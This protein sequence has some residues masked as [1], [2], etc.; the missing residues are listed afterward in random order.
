MKMFN[1]RPKERLIFSFINRSLKEL[2]NNLPCTALHEL[3]LKISETNSKEKN[4]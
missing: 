2:I 4:E 3:K 1:I